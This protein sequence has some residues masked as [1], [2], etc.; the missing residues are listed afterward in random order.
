MALQETKPGTSQGTVGGLM[1][2]IE[3]FMIKDDF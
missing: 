2:S 3:H 1:Y